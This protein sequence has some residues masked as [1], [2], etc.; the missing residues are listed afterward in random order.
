MR[1]TNLKARRAKVSPFPEGRGLGMGTRYRRMR[2][3]KSFA[4]YSNVHIVKDVELAKLE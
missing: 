1:K 4:K 3:G 2:V